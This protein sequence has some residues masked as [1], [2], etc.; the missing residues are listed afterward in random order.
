[1]SRRVNRRQFLQAG[2]ISAAAAGFWL[3]GGVTEVRRRK[4]PMNA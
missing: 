3:T 4:D 2:S 1:M